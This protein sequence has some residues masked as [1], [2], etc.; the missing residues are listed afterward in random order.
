MND[1]II[2]YFQDGK[3]AIAD[4]GE[5]LSKPEIPPP[6]EILDPSGFDTE[7]IVDLKD[8][9]R[10]NKLEGAYADN[11]E[12][13]STQYDLLREDAIRP[14][15]E[16]VAEVRKDPWRDELEYPQSSGIGI[17]EP[18]YITS[19][20]FS[21]RG[22]AARVAFSLGRVKKFI[23][24]KQ[25][26]RLITGT[27]VAL[28]PAN[29]AF[30]SQ[31]IL[32]TVAARPLSGLE[33]ANPP[34]IDLFFAR[35]QDFQLDTMR[36]WIM[37]ECR[38]SFFEA[39]RHT[40]SALQHMMH[41]LFPLSEHL[42]HA[43]K[44]IDPPA[45]VQDNPH[46]DMSSLVSLEE[47]EKFQNVHILEEWPAGDTH[48]L[49]K[50]Q[51]K[52]LKR[53]LTNRLA[54]VQG[55]PGTGKTHVSVVALKILLA[56]LRND[57][58]PIIVTCQT[59]HALDQLLLHVTEFEAN[60]IR[61]GGRSKDQDKIKKRTLF[62]V[63]QG[64]QQPRDPRS[65]KNVAMGR[66]KQL[67]KKMQDVL[68]PFEQGKGCLDHRLLVRIGL[69]TETQAESLK[70]D[71]QFAMGIVQDTPGIQLEQWLGKS[72]VE[73][74]RPVQPDD[75][76]MDYEEEDFDEVEQLEELEAEAVARDND[77][78]EALKGPV[79]SL[80]DNWTG[81]S[82]GSTS[83]EYIRKK[84]DET[85]D[86][87]MIPPPERGG[88]YKYFQRK[89]KYHILGEFRNLA[90][91]YDD[92]VLERKIGQWEQD[93]RLLAEQRLVGM[94]TTGLS[95][96]RALI[97]SLRPRIVLVEEA[98]ETLEAPVTAACVPSLE[99]LILVGDHQQLRPHCQLH[100][101]EDEPYYF[102][103]SLFERMVINNI[104][105]DTLTRQRRMIPEIR[106]LLYPI[107]R[108]TIKDH[109][110]VTDIDN[111][112]HVE[113][114]GGCNS[115][116]FT[117]SWPEQRDH[118]MSAFNNGE[119][120]M[121]V[122]LVNHLVLNEVDSRKITIL[123]F[124]NGQRNVLNKRLAFHQN[125]RGRSFKVATVDSYQG[126]ENDIVILSLVRSNKNR[127]IGFLSVDNRVCVALS[128]A[129]RGFYIFGNAE[130][131]AI[132][133]RTWESV[134]R[135]LWGHD[136]DLKDKKITLAG[137]TC[138]IGYHFPLQC[139]VHGNKVWIE[140]P[141]DWELINGGCDQPCR[142]ILPCGHT[143]MLKCHP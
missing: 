75:F 74:R 56:N 41:E 30:K 28:S 54:I 64:M 72:L 27:L 100:A 135:I 130:M 69:I 81:R 112:P 142:C 117:H 128:R 113:G 67:T 62:E 140:T 73:S 76:G 11:Q 103:L 80:S 118:N 53:I 116:F 35:P 52:A 141:D 40:L 85:P 38:S 143:C 2:Q 68:A 89:T 24:W 12:Y 32:A 9:L 1:D 37:V 88:I 91:Q 96:Y 10:P 126:E 136:K 23:R 82:G 105:F 58:P 84:L 131:L 57:D 121:I 114:M 90:V 123:T 104:E 94:T 60:F 137:P 98:A 63:R 97:A 129:K 134:V 43:K 17:Y 33:A 16:A 119:A 125:L 46:T 139:A 51:S 20:V 79:M 13:L 99:H 45:Y 29:D 4:G 77:D 120:D 7:Q 5:W 8:E 55:P 115:F 18:T 34:E 92:A 42:V 26:K 71:A 36:K 138:R 15:R 47:A 50:S 124:Y 70:F 21:P 93:Q 83:D 86:L 87:G 61:L 102:N 122:G 6:S 22:L 31:C 48:S 109:K 127:N 111:R 133:S 39:S 132:E 65:R 25:S 101:F 14:L 78:I 66:I 110:S 19:V 3:K 108:D 106:R 95:K 44:E 49:D 107:Y 59:N